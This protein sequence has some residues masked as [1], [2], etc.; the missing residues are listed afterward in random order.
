[1]QVQH[2][3]HIGGTVGRVLC[4]FGEEQQVQLTWTA[5]QTAYVAPAR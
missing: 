1:V 4:D 2:E 3:S 5:S